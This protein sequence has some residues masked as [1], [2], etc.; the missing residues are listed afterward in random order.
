MLCILGESVPHVLPSLVGTIGGVLVAKK[1]LV[2]AAVLL[3]L[4]GAGLW[5]AGLFDDDPAPEVDEVALR[6]GDVAPLVAPPV[7]EVLCVRGW[8]SW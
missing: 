1:M 6:T 7:L 2:I 3:V 8:I 4:V 5:R